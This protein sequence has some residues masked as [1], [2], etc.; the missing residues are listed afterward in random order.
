MAPLS[1]PTPSCTQSKSSP[2][3]TVA[4]PAGVTTPS[5]KSKGSQRLVSSGNSTGFFVSE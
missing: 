1:E 2:G 3:L 5:S 4:K